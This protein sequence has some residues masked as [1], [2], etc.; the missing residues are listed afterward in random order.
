MPHSQTI[1]RPYAKAAYEY[2][3]ASGKLEH[4]SVFLDTAGRFCT[5]EKV[6]VHL[7]ERGFFAQL[8]SWLN[9]Y[10]GATRKNGLDRQE[11]NFLRLLD[12]HDRMTILADIAREFRRLR[13]AS[14]GICEARVHTAKPLND[15]QLKKIRAFIARKTDKTVT[16]TIKE[17]PD[18]LAGVRIEY[19]GLVIDQSARARIGEFA[20]KL[21]ESRK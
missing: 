11:R 20:R 4:W 16:I 13:Y 12:A 21:E 3:V 8:E 2:A 19:D 14:K 1:A 7:P 15:T 6:R 9:Q 5:D 18:L 17:A 10:L